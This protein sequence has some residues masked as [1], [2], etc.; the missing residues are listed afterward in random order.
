[1]KFKE[2]Q[3]GSALYL[4]F[5]RLISSAFYLFVS[6]VL[7]PIHFYFVWRGHFPGPDFWSCVG[8]SENSISIL[9]VNFW[10]RLQWVNRETSG[11]CTRN[12]GL[13]CFISRSSVLQ[14]SPS[15][16]WHMA[17]NAVKGSSS[18]SSSHFLF[19]ILNDLQWNHF[20]NTCSLMI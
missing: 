14:G 1:M 6:R 11:G 7:P 9:P 10:V 17:L 4:F 5:Y 3:K 8:D 12:R 2:T 13:V 20:V 16:H 19:H 18:S 15:L